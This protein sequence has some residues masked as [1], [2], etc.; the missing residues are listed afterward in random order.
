MV[1]GKEA[2]VKR[3]QVPRETQQE[4]KIALFACIHSLKVSNKNC[5]NSDQMVLVRCQDPKI[6][7]TFR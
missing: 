6:S 5:F 3:L 4:G 1:L 7:K 2:A